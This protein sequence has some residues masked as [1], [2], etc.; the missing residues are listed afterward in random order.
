MP[1]Y[2]TF[3]LML[4]LCG[5]SALT[6]ITAA[7]AFVQMTTTPQLRGRV[8]A[9][10]MAIFM[11]GTPIGAPLLGWIAEHFGAR[12]TLVGAAVALDRGSARSLRATACAG[13]DDAQ[14]PVRF[15]GVLSRG[16][17]HAGA[18]SEQGVDELV[19]VERDEVADRLADADELDGEAELGL[20]GEHDA[21][22]GRAV[23]LGQH[24]ARDLRGVA[25]LAGLGEAVLARSWRR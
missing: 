10:Y 12:W 19:G 17:P 20:D 6:V 25:E 7:N 15:F 18:G 16:F 11:G 23:E 22:L 14:R 9:L 2:L 5:L 3:A 21:A 8:M 1:T 13:P 4:P 24:D